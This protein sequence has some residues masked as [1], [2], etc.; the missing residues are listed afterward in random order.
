VATALIVSTVISELY[1]RDPGVAGE[2]DH[3]VAPGAR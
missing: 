3:P 2:P 1:F